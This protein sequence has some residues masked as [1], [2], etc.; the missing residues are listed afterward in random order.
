M[1][2]KLNLGCGYNKIPF[3]VNVDNDYKCNPDLVHDLECLPL[4]F[5][6][7]SVSEIILDNVLEHLGKD[8]DVYFNLWKEFYRICE[9]DA[10]ITIKVP[11]PRH[12]NFLHDPTH[13]RIVTPEGLNLFS[14]E[15]NIKDEGGKSSKLGLRLDI[16]FQITEVKTL[17]DPFYI[18]K[19]GRD[20]IERDMFLYNN[21]CY[22][23]I[24]VLRCVK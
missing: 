23:N 4:P 3:F 10:I 1:G 6:D 21:V 9:K 15:V 11:H 20:N 13:C 22:E 17:A 8:V 19:F 12:N 14:K 24:I 7:N 2:I 18:D 16:D 5:E